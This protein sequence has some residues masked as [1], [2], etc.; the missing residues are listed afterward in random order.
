[1]LNV[2]YSLMFFSFVAL[3]FTI[4]QTAVSSEESKP[5]ELARLMV[6]ID[7][8]Y[9]SCE[10]ISGYY[11]YDD[12]EWDIIY[13]AGTDV[14]KM[15]EKVQAKYGRP[16]NKKYEDLMEAMR[17]AAQKM[18]DIAKKSR[19]EDGAL[20]DAQWQVR[21]LRNTCAN[22]H[23]LINIHI[24]HNLYPKKKHRREEGIFKDWGKPD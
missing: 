3:L 18:A 22:C 15:T 11:D 13:H 5:S 24:Y 19:G 4:N 23:R 14:A 2:K 21:K 6:A 17:Y 9:K 1:M 10:E 20:E 7:K 8:S 12:E 16:D